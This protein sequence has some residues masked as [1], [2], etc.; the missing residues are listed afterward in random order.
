MKCFKGAGAKAPDSH[1]QPCFSGIEPEKQGKNRH[2][3]IA[4]IRQRSKGIKRKIDER[5]LLLYN[6]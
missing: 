6:V 1:C 5:Y 2:A 4:G 3:A